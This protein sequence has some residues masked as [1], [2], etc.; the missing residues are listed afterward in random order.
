MFVH[1]RG[2]GRVF[3]YHYVPY[4]FESETFSPA[5]PL[6]KASKSPKSS[7]NL[8]PNCWNYRSIPQCW[9]WNLVLRLTQKIALTHEILSPVQIFM[10]NQNA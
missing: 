3:L 5:S 8:S 10:S 7:Y 4:S 1:I 6:L 9:D 2:K